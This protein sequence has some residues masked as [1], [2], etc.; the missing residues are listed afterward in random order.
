MS[1]TS[2][3]RKSSTGLT[4]EEYVEKMRRRKLDDN[5]PRIKRQANRKN[6]NVNQKQNP[7]Q[8]RNINHQ[9]VNQANSNQ[10]KLNKINNFFFF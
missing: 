3:K 5:E 7:R 6:A 1:R 9:N 10:D 4:R 2:N 8:I